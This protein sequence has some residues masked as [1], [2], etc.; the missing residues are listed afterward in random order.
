M[1]VVGN[2]NPHY[3]LCCHVD[4]KRKAPFQEALDS[5][6]SLLQHSWVSTLFYYHTS[7]SG[8]RFLS[9]RGASTVSCSLL[10]QSLLHVRIQKLSRRYTYSIRTHSWQFLLRKTVRVAVRLPCT[11]FFSAQKKKKPSPLWAVACAVAFAR[12]HTQTPVVYATHPSTCTRQEVHRLGYKGSQPARSDTPYL[13][14]RGFVFAPSGVQFVA[15]YYAVFGWWALS[16][17]NFSSPSFA[18]AA[19]KRS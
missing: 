10:T 16:T 8:E 9:P 4:R 14:C 12:A 18:L 11:V 6:M 15:L 1:P 13:W 3:N 19:T 5:D 7:G 2:F 17:R